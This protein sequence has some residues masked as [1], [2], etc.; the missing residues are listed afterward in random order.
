MKTQICKKKFC[1]KNCVTNEDEVNVFQEF[2][3]Y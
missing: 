3:D 2:E 1:A